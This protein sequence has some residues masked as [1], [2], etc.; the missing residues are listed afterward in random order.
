LISKVSLTV[1]SIYCWIAGTILLI[2]L[3]KVAL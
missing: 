1:F 3:P 2:I